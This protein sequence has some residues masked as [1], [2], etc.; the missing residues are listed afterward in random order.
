[1]VKSPEFNQESGPSTLGTELGTSK[2]R[3]PVRVPSEATQDKRDMIFDL[4]SH[5]PKVVGSNPTPATN[6]LVIQQGLPI[7]ESEAFLFELKIS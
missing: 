4:T 2:S 6:Y 5:N 7:S 1:M 3:K